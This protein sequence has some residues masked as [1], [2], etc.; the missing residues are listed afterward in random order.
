MDQE[1][2]FKVNLF[3]LKCEPWGTNVVQGDIPELRG[4]TESKRKDRRKIFQ[5]LG[6]PLIACRITTIRKEENSGGSIEPIFSKFS[7]S[8]RLTFIPPQF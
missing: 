5:I 2:D 1:S 3:P 8:A 7:N 4:R 6:R